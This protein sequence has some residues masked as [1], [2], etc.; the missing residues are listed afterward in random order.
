M[1][2]NRKKCFSPEHY[3]A[4]EKIDSEEGHIFASPERETGVQYWLHYT[5]QRA[6]AAFTN[7]STFV[8]A[9]RTSSAWQKLVGKLCKERSLFESG[10]VP[11]Q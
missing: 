9:V 5:M 11:G 7:T 2:Q 8:E 4:Y 10:A 1:Q 3:K 6:T